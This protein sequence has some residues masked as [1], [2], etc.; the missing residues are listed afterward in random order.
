MLSKR[1]SL[2]HDWHI[3]V[4]D[5]KHRSL[6]LFHPANNAI[7][8]LKGCI[9]PVTAITGQGKGSQSR[10]AFNKLIAEVFPA[11]KKQIVYLRI[12]KQ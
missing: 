12:E 9:A 8:E 5:V 11:L 7:K 10:L 2:K 4:E 1:W 6:I 3:E